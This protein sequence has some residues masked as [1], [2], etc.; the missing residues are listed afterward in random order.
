MNESARNKFGHDTTTEEVLE[1]IDLTGKLALV[2]GAS[3]GLGAETARAL[4][5]Q[6]AHVVICCRSRNSEKAGV[7][8]RG[9]GGSA[10]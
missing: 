2:T 8:F 4:T 1:G 7:R 6:G 5:S 3:S 10:L 9:D